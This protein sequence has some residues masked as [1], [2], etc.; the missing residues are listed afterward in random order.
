MLKSTVNSECQRNYNWIVPGTQGSSVRKSENERKK[1][2]KETK[3][4]IEAVYEK[5]LQ[6][7]LILQ[8]N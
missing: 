6:D 7:K 5:V 4:E 1:D 2:V 8:D 3:M